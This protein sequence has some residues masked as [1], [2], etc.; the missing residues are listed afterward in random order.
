[1][2][3][4]IRQWKIYCSEESM[5]FSLFIGSVSQLTS[6]LSWFTPIVDMVDKAQAWDGKSSFLCGLTIFFWKQKV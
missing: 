2:H 5:S 4:N 6:S 1:M 3:L